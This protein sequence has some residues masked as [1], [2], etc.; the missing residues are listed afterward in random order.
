MSLQLDT[1]GQKSS[2]GNV[3]Q[4]TVRVKNRLGLHLRPASKLVKLASSFAECEISIQK[5]DQQVNAK[6]VMGVIMLAAEQGSEL[7][8]EIIGTDA[9]EALAQITQLIEEGFGEE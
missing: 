2:G 7:Y 4:A 1:P 8:I 6:S 3:Q 5:D 9:A